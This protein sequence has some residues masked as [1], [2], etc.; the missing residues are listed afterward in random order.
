MHQFA[1]KHICGRMQGEVVCGRRC[2]A[3]HDGSRVS[4]YCSEHGSPL[5]RSLDELA[6]AAS[7]ASFLGVGEDELDMWASE[8]ASMSV[9][10]PDSVGEHQRFDVT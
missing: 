7:G 4:H 2:D 1:C 5:K 8:E 3:L 6:D 10:E 9:P